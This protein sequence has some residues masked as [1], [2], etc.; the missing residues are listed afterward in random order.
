MMELLGPGYGRWV[1]TLVTGLENA[2]Y[3]GSGNLENIEKKLA[4]VFGGILEEDLVFLLDT[5][6]GN[7]SR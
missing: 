5:F 4:V 7:D 6:D 3:L 2:N 1:S